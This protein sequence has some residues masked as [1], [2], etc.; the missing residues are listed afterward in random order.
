MAHLKWW[1]C[2]SKARAVL[3]AVGHIL[4]LVDAGVAQASLHAGGAGVV[5]ASGGGGGSFYAF[6]RLGSP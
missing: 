2:T 6:G 3:A 1:E 5:V 4:L